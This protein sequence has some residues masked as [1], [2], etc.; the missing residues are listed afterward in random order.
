MWLHGIGGSKTIC[1]RPY[2]R[3]KVVDIEG[4]TVWEGPGEM[5]LDMIG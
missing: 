5:L 2:L 1:Y 3:V 4:P